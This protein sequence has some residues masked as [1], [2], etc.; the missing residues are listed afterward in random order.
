ML[1]AVYHFSSL[2]VLSLVCL[3]LSLAHFSYTHHQ[4]LRLS[5]LSLSTV[6]SFCS[7]NVMSSKLF[8]ITGP[9]A[10]TGGPVV[11]DLLQRGHKVRALVRKLDDRSQA[12]QKAGAEVV[13]GDLLDFD[14][15][16]AALKGVTAAYFVYPIEPGLIEATAFFAQAAKESGVTAIVN[17][18]QIS[19]KSEASSRGA[20][21]HWV[22][23]RVFDWSGVPTTHIRPTFFSEWLLYFRA[24]ILSGRPLR[25]PFSDSKH[26]PIA[27]ADQARVIVAILLDPAT[28]AGQ[29]YPLFGPVEL[30]HSEIVAEANKT[31]GG[32]KP[33]QYE[34]CSVPEFGKRWRTTQPFLAQHLEEVAKAHMRGE[35]AGTNDVVERL[36]GR[37][38]MTVAEFVESKRSELTAV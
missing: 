8:L 18:S 24:D 35:F 1:V 30:T 10:D 19:A 7:C 36:T 2:S 38:P 4:R 37:T 15:V 22:A 26:A 21:N 13:V 9:N 5:A 27:A 23:E 34:V 32:S 31:L 16:R 33:I 11:T 29:T 28:H 3:S 20:R 17:M 6:L 12:L 25:M 14:S